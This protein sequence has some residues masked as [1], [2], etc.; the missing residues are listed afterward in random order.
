MFNKLIAAILPFF[1]KKFIWIF[2][3]S[4]ISGET[5]E[6]AMRVSKDLNSKKIKVTLDI[7]GEFIE[8][9]EEAES[10][11][12]EYLNLID[13]SHK[14][15]IDGNFSLKPT[16]FGLLFDKN[17]CFNHILEIVAKAGSYNSFIRIDMEDSPSTDLEI[18]L[19]RKLKAEFPRNVGLVVQ[20]YLKR[21]LRDIEQLNDLNTSEI[22]INFRLCKG[23]YIE[24]AAIA[25]KKYEEINQHYLEDLEY[26]FR[27]KIYVGIATHDKPLVEGAYKLIEKYNIPKNMYEFQMLYGVTPKLRESILNGGHT[28]RVYVPYGKQWFGYSTRRLKE[29]PKM[30]SHIMK[31]V[32]Y[33]G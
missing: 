9:P 6:D 12:K 19:F 11:K 10:N 7:L 28:M 24:P 17:L 29:N 18:E 22:P 15:E 16:S 26:M 31:A 13:V 20:A 33:K 5:I 27:N 14:N 4:Y 25:Y 2:S 32:F 21:T 30:A 23:I 8:T 1:P 3:K